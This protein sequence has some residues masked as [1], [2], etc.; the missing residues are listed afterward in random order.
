MQLYKT[1][2]LRQYIGDIHWLEKKQHRKILYN[3]V[4]A[5]AFNQLVTSH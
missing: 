1:I 5:L 4:S 2:K 3:A